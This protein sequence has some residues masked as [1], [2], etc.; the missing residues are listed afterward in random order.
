M[1]AVFG[2]RVSDRED[3][4]LSCKN[5]LK[6][7]VSRGFTN[8]AA[9]RIIFIRIICPLKTILS[10]SALNTHTGSQTEPRM[11]ILDDQI[12]KIFAWFG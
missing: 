1:T 8:G 6:E 2:N 5:N 11:E 12:R 10:P 3:L 7:P 4:F 9:R